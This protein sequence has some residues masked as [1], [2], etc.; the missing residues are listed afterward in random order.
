MIVTKNEKLAQVNLSSADLMQI[1]DAIQCLHADIRS[2]KRQIGIDQ[3]E[4]YAYLLR[5]KSKLDSCP[6]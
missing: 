3:K 2:Q 1:I 6:E 5:H 4:L